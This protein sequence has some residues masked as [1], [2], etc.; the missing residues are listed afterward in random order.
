MN[1]NVYVY[2]DFEHGYTQYPDNYTKDIIKSVTH[3]IKNQGTCQVAIRR[4]D[5]LAYLIYNYMYRGDK[6]FG[7]CLEYNKFCPHNICYIFD[8]FDSI[9]A[10]VMTKGEILHYTTSG[11][12]QPSARYLHENTGTIDYYTRLIHLTFD[13]EQAIFKKLPPTNR[14]IDYDRTIIY[15]LQ[16]SS[17]SIESA[18]KDNNIIIISRD[19]DVDSIHSYKKL[20][21]RINNDKQKL[22][23]Y[24]HELQNENA[25]LR[26]QKNN[27][28]LVMI[29]SLLVMGCGIG[30]YF[31]N[32]HLHT[33]QQQLN[34][35]QKTITEK[36]I[37]INKKNNEISSLKSSRDSLQKEFNEEH[38][39]RVT[40]EEYLSKLSASNPLVITSCSVY[41]SSF[42]FNYFAYEEK[43]ITVTLKAINESN[44]NIISN[45][46]TISL[47]KGF[48]NQKL[49]FNYRLNSSYYYHV[50]LIYDGRIIAGT[51]W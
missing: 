30:I 1:C 44:S 27:Y 7:F 3:K 4:K 35:A 39:T 12:V 2:G 24:N 28:L 6:S 14:S 33:T 50:V 42:R 20:L 48:G 29:M 36:N 5:D 43:E 41:N 23:E 11:N 13:D 47:S 51:R 15:Q 40:L 16:D 10:D 32:Q 9:I 46:H 18:L 19:A 25:K 38:N 21:K 26:R 49:D 17:C 31:L 8:F 45:R 34:E 22:F 37:I